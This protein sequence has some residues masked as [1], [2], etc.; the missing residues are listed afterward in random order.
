[1]KN[2]YTIQG[3]NKDLQRQRKF[4]YIPIIKQINRKKEKMKTSEENMKRLEISE[5]NIKLFYWKK[6]E[7]KAKKYNAKYNDLIKKLTK[8]GN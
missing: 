8:K 6:K 3:I 5:Y 7:K 2:N 4:L 1:M